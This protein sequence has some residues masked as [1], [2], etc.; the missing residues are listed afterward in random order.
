[1]TT[2]QL[3]ILSL[4]AAQAEMDK[5][6][7][8]EQLEVLYKENSFKALIPSVYGGLEL[9]LPEVVMLEEKI[10]K[11][12]GSTGWVMT[13]CAGAGWF[14]GFMEPSFAKQ[15][16]EGEKVCLAGSGA[17]TGTAEIT[18]D[19]F[20]VNGRWQYASGASDATAFTANC[21]I[22]ENSIPVYNPDGTKKIL[23]FAFLKREVT[24]LLEWSSIGMIATASYTYQVKKLFVPNERSFRIDGTAAVIQT[25]LY[26]Y[27]FLQLAEVTLAANILGMGLHFIEKANKVLVQKKEGGELSDANAEIFRIVIAEV[28]GQINDSRDKMYHALGQSWSQ[29]EAKGAIEKSVLN[30]VS[31]TARE[32]AQ[33]AVRG[34]DRIYPYCGLRSANPNTE[35]NR[36]WRD[37]HTA[38]QHSLLV[39][40]R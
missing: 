16:F 34:V 38:S 5:K 12:D 10:A 27:P 29:C 3:E 2:S 22:I 35:I 13:L 11:A 23:A 33:Q 8:A 9:S 6:L 26:R 14:G 15:I 36:V 7:C 19:G 24:L 21:I 37:L 32:V 30:D 39:F 1:M 17:P 31:K 4:Y 18:G 28:T 25:A 20:V 40:E